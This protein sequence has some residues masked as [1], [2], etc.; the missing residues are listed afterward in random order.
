[1]EAYRVRIEELEGRLTSQD[2]EMEV[3]QSNPNPDTKTNIG[4][5]TVTFI[6]GYRL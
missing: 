6:Q 3:L 5:H 1:M 4:L 2:L